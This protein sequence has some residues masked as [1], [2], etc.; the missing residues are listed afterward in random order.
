[1]LK[2]QLNSK[3]FYIGT[4]RFNDNTY[5]ENL[6][7][8]KKKNHKGCCYG[9]DKP[10]TTKVP[11]G[12]NIF[13]I[14][15]NNETNSIMG[16]GLIRNIYKSKNRSR[17]Y[18]NGC[19][20]S[21][22]Y[23]SQ[24]HITIEEIL[25]KNEINKSIIIFLE[26]L[27][28]YGSGHFKRGQGCIIIPYDRISTYFHQ[29]DIKKVLKKLRPTMRCRICGL[30]LKGHKCKKVKIMN[31][32]YNKKCR[33]CGLTKKG[34]ICKGLIKNLKLLEVILNFFKILFD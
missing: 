29:I 3:P 24:Y 23:K 30:P 25:A 2:Q 17:I 31:I 33:I 22:V 18:K 11:N 14:E 12:E 16:I 10:I 5:Q 32:K 26:R 8:K 34:H 20:N 7:W 9:F 4:A 1:M 19:W 13:V 28:F 27:L 6:N 15:M 21:Y